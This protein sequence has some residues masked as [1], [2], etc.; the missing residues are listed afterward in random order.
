MCRSWCAVT[1]DEDTAL[2]FP[3]NFAPLRRS[4]WPHGTLSPSVPS[5][6]A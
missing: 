3:R 1:S 4:R 5:A 6:A 2:T